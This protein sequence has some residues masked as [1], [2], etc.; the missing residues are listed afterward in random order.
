MEA[1][2]LTVEAR[3]LDE[4]S[5]NGYSTQATTPRV[6]FRALVKPCF[7]SVYRLAIMSVVYPMAAG[8]TVA[9]FLRECGQES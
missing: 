8:F 7:L 1:V 3:L 6:D 2:E 4:N 5:H 9:R